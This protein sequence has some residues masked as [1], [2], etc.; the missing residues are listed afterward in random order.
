MG[1][2][3]DCAILQQNSDHNLYVSTDTSV[4]GVHFFP[5]EDAWSVGWKALAVNL[6][7]LAAS[8]AKPLGFTL[9]L[10]LPQVN[11]PWLTAFSQGLLSQAEL[12]NCPLVG[13][14]TTSTRPDSPLVISIAI[15]GERSH[16]ANCMARSAAQKDDQIWVTGIPGLARLG[17][18][19]R[20]DQLGRLPELLTEPQQAL[21][22]Q[23]WAALPPYL[24]DQA[25][26]RLTRPVVRSQ[27][28]LEASVWMHAALDL[29]D[30]VSGDLNH[31]AKAS[32]KCLLLQESLLQAMWTALPGMEPLS[33]NHDLLNFLLE[34]SLIGG[35]DYEL[36]FTASPTDATKLENL[37]KAN[38]I[39]LSILGQ[40][41][42]S[43]SLVPGVVIQ[44]S[45]GQETALRSN[46]FNHFAP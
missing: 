19:R 37:A 22:R 33:A 21:F 30:G 1:I 3:D 8:G 29:S 39:S 18:L 46:S 34:S 20:Y 43:K 41:N 42:A 45:K 25:L 12:A 5:D 28:A 7:D 31:I 23:T 2:G 27:F 9:N 24:Q 15:F 26:T 35:D 38:Q 44:D 4:A 14:D 40:V 6:S 11:H 16:Q 36:C 13:G 32:S 17:L 10:S